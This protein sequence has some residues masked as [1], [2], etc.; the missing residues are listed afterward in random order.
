MLDDFLSSN[1]EFFLAILMDCGELGIDQISDLIAKNGHYLP[2]MDVAFKDDKLGC[3]C[4]IP[5]SL[6]SEFVEW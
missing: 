3:T 4:K 1:M 5:A 6:C 2:S